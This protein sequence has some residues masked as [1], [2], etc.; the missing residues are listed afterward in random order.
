MKVLGKVPNYTYGFRILVE[1]DPNTSAHQLNFTANDLG[2]ALVIHWIAWIQ[3]F[4]FI[5]K[6]IPG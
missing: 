2:G 6:H 4:D 1:T 5:A 3:L